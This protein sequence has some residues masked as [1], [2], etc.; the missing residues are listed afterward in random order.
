MNVLSQKQSEPQRKE[1]NIQTHIK[2][3]TK[4]EA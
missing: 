2:N 4:W 3:Q 1:H